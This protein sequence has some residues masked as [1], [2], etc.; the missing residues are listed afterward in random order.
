[1]DLERCLLALFP[2]L[3]SVLRTRRIFPPKLLLTEI[4]V[5]TAHPPGPLR[6]RL[7]L[8]PTLLVGSVV[9]GTILPTWAF[10]IANKHVFDGGQPFAGP[11]VVWLSYVSGAW[12]SLIFGLL[13]WLGRATD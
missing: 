3:A 4:T 12:A 5:S 13:V 8:L 11:S 9:L 1:M 6:R 10:L 2:L 7:P